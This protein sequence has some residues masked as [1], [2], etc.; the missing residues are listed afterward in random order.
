MYVP[1]GN[2]LAGPSADAVTDAHPPHPWSSRRYRVR[3]QRA[4]LG[5]HARGTGCQSLKVDVDVA[6]GDAEEFF[7]GGRIFRHAEP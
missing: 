7:L 5:V 2:T 3:V 1:R 4:C 6:L